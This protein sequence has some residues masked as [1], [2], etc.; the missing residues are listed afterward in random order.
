MGFV[1]TILCNC[2]E[3][4]YFILFIGVVFYGYMLWYFF[5]I[6]LFVQIKKSKNRTIWPIVLLILSVIIFLNLNRVCIRYILNWGCFLYWVV[7][8]LNK[9]CGFFDMRVGICFGIDVIGIGCCLM[10]K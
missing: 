7:L 2:F 6:F 5:W 3:Y 8:S 9:L 1:L 10:N 4:V